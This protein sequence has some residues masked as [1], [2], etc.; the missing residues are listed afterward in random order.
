MQDGERLRA[1]PRRYNAWLQ[2]SVDEI[3]FFDIF[4]I[5]VR[6]HT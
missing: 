5:A 1:L 3:A 6:A 2:F 4:E